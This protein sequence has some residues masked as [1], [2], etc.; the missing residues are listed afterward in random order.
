[1]ERREEGNTHARFM[2]TRG[3]VF[4]IWRLGA[5]SM[6]LCLELLLACV[7]NMTVSVLCLEWNRTNYRA[8][9][10]VFLPSDAG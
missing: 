10:S 9:G 6:E 8:G 1:M 3:V 4:E 7:Q 5:I 2:V